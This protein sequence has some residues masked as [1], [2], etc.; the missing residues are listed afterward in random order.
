[1]A[2]NVRSGLKLLDDLRQAGIAADIDYQGRSMRAQMRAAN[3]SGARV[4]L[5]L[6][7]D[8]VARGEVSLKDMEAGS[9]ETL[10]LAEAVARLRPQADASV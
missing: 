2:A 8:E 5:I 4:A 7:E 9:Q 6:G 1:M 10:P 3:R